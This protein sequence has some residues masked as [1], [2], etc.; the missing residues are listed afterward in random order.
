MSFWP[1]KIYNVYAGKWH[2]HS[3]Q[4]H[5]CSLCLALFYIMQQHQQEK[6]QERLCRTRKLCMVLLEVI[7]ML[8]RTSSFVFRIM[9][10]LFSVCVRSYLDLRAHN[11]FIICI[12]WVPAELRTG[13]S[14]VLFPSFAR[15]NCVFA[16]LQ[17][18][19]NKHNRPSK[20][21][22]KARAPLLMRRRSAL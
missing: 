2:S 13:V 15:S 8:I 7:F 5:L 6:K 11:N 19:N 4:L 3:L 21:L 10:S 1:Q 12:H 17:S 14:I 16:R 9:S 20:W 22:E 18:E